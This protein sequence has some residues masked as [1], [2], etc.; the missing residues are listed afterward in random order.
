MIVTC[1]IS[2]VVNA[3]GIPWITEVNAKGRVI[4]S[5]PKAYTVDFTQGLVGT[6]LF[7]GPESYRE[8]VVGKERCSLK[9][10][11]IGA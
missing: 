1:L 11:Q 10:N 9:T 4:N 7:K 3:S 6:D 8:V 2:V 5:S